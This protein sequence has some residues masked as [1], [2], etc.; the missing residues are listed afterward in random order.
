MC[1]SRPGKVETLGSYLEE[2]FQLSGGFK[3]HLSIILLILG[4][5]LILPCLALLAI[6]SVSSLTEAMVKRKMA[7]HV[8]MLWKYKPLNQDDAL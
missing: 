7:M 3:T 5:C 8:M 1:Q 6:W 4:A 2:G